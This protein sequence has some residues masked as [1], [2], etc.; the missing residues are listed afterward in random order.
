MARIAI[1]PARSG[2]KRIPKKNFLKIN[3]KPMVSHAIGLAESTDL[4]DEIVVSLDSHGE[5]KLFESEAV[6]LHYRPNDLGKDDAT[7]IDVIRDVITE[8]GYS[9]SDFICCLY[10]ASFLL[11]K[12]RITQSL[13]I[14][15]SNPDRFVF[16]AQPVYSHP[17]RAFVH[18]EDKKLIEFLDPTALKFKT[19]DLSIFYSDAGQLYWGKQTTWE[20]E[21]EILNALSV[22]LILNRW[23]TVD[24]DYPED[25]DLALIMLTRKSEGEAL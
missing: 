1:I 21:R 9:E 18:N 14:L 2:S 24:I 5:D 8:R 4:F 7:T 23:E 20:Q 3:G 22:P 10:P 19:Q 6:A 17:L 12:Q 13:S 25:V 11:A 16:T 15:E